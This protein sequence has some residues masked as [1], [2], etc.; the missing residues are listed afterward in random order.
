MIRVLIVVTI[1]TAIVFICYKKQNQ[2]S[3]RYMY[4]TDSNPSDKINILMIGNSFIY[5]NSMWKT[6]QTMLGSKYNVDRAAFPSISL[7]QHISKGDLA[8]ILSSK[9]YDYI[10]L[11]EKSGIPIKTP[12]NLSENVGR[13]IS[14]I[15]KYQPMG[16]KPVLY[17]TYSRCYLQDPNPE[18]TQLAIDRAFRYASIS[19]GDCAVAEVGRA[20]MKFRLTDDF[21]ITDPILFNCTD[22]DTSHPSELGSLLTA[23][24]FYRFFTSNPAETVNIPRTPITRSFFDIVDSL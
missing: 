20:F 24:V 13:M 11:Q 4:E 22:K 18:K 23:L 5:K 9:R 21:K 16:W 7:K 17:E 6:L 14:Y 1:L 3:Y 2:E 19:N 12:E 8:K 15:N 10:V